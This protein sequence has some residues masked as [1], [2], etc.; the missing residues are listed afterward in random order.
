M[1]KSPSAELGGSGST[2]PHHP[3]LASSHPSSH[4]A[5][6]TR[7]RAASLLPVAVLV[8]QTKPLGSP[9]EDED[10][11]NDEDDSARGP[12]PLG[13][14]SRCHAAV[15]LTGRARRA[16]LARGIVA[17]LVAGGSLMRGPTAWWLVVW[18][19]WPCIAGAGQA[20]ADELKARLELKLAERRRQALALAQLHE[21]SGD[22][23]RA[24]AHYEATRRIRDDDI[25]VLTRLLRLYRMH[26]DD[27]SLLSP[28]AALVRLQPA[29]IGWRRELGSCYFRL[30]RHDRAEAAWRKMLEVHSDRGAALRY[31]GQAYAQHGLDEKAVDAFRQS[32][33]LNPRDSY[34]RLL[35]AQALGRTGRHLEVLAALSALKGSSTSRSSRARRA[36]DA[37]F[38]G[39][40]LPRPVRDA[41]E[42]LLDAGERSVADLA[43]ALAQ[44][45]EQHGDRTR[46][47]A[48]YRR[49]ADAEPKTARGKQA[50]AQARQLE[51]TP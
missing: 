7:I 17:P 33:A 41:A 39:L 10:E 5:S 34:V 19:G 35:F 6:T 18:L 20:T 8:L 49:V 26:G 3:R 2:A 45:L 47:A 48:L 24:A 31:L 25:Q 9:I 28:L 4:A 11:D 16:T 30:G 38:Q 13:V 46:A 32:L 27:A 1:T 21:A 12:I 36:R 22:W 42:K 37:A 44:A 29:S 43:W 40:G 50:A 51:P 23:Q 15:R 14:E